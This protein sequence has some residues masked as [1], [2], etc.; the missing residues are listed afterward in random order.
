MWTRLHAVVL[1]SRMTIYPVD[2]SVISLCTIFMHRV[3]LYLKRSTARMYICSYPYLFDT[4][5]V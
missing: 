1:I 5:P 3:K 2:K 4:I